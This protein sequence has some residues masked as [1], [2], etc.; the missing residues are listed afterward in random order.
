MREQV[1]P[2]KVGNRAGMSRTRRAM[3]RP[4]R[5]ARARSLNNSRPHNRATAG[6]LRLVFKLVVAIAIGIFLF[7]SYRAVG[8]ASFF[9]LRKIE[10]QGSSRASVEEIEKVVRRDVRQ[11]GVWNTDLEDLS[12][13]LRSLPWVSRAVVTRVLPDGIRVRVQERTPRAVS[14]LASGRLT[15]VD[16]EAVILGQLSPTDPMPP[17]FLVGLSEEQTDNAAEQNVER[18]NKFLELEREWTTAG[19]AERVSEVNLFDVRDVRAQ[20]SGADSQIEVRLGAQD[21]SRR[22]YR[23]LEVLD[24]QRQTPRGNLISYVD[25]SQGKRAVIGFI[26]GARA[27]GSTS[28]QASGADKEIKGEQPKTD[29]KE[30]RTASNMEGERNKKDHRD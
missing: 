10:V 7:S 17:F 12:V 28:E 6:Y 30:R 16:D 14:R 3:Q 27:F 15:W 24:G 18:V 13:K 19:L 4:A 8:S 1:I 26:S 22:L 5:R 20:L 2:Q 9:Q 25:L 11:T 29:H 23:A 21:L